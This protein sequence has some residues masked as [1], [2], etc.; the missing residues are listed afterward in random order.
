[1]QINDF[2]NR[3]KRL[4]SELSKGKGIN[5]LDIKPNKIYKV[6]ISNDK[7]Y[8][9]KTLNDNSKTVENLK[10]N[11]LLRKFNFIVRLDGTWQFY[12]NYYGYLDLP[13]SGDYK[14]TQIK[15]IDLIILKLL[16]KLK[17]MTKI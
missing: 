5:I 10:R 3:K 17:P 15:G 12:K 1:M 9:I 16:K 6:I 11:V 7:I 4:L 8:I 2:L 13:K 14:I